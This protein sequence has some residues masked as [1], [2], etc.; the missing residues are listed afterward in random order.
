[1]EKTNNWIQ[2]L[3]N[4]PIE[5]IRILP[6]LAE[7]EITRNKRYGYILG[8]SIKTC[9]GW[10]VKQQKTATVGAFWKAPTYFIC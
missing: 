2:N 4:Y 6:Y 10:A 9:I 7:K 1:M 5:T 3:I 8:K